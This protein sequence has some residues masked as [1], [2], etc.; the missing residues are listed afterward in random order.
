MYVKDR[1]LFWHLRRSADLSI[2]YISRQLQYY[3]QINERTHDDKNNK[4][5][6]EEFHVEN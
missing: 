3:M 5:V 2:S 6:F 4:T 1:V